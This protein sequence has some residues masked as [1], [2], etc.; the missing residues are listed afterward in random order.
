MDGSIHFLYFLKQISTEKEKLDE[1]QINK[2]KEIRNSVSDEFEKYDKPSETVLFY[3]DQL[4][5]VNERN[6]GFDKR[7]ELCTRL[8]FNMIFLATWRFLIDELIL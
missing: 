4:L 7:R 6:N 3:F 1:N 2:L 8:K 5:V